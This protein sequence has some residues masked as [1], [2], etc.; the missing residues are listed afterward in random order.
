MSNLFLSSQFSDNIRSSPPPPLR[1]ENFSQQINPSSIR[2]NREEQ[3]RPPMRSRAPEQS[4]TRRN[5][6]KA[7]PI[8]PTS[9]S[10][11][12][13]RSTEKNETVARQSTQ[14]QSSSAEKQEVRQ[15]GANTGIERWSPWD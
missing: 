1:R 14:N 12:P 15:T 5:D 8:A 10:P 3:P 2:S 11:I 13:Q 7:N 6:P 4:A 9:T